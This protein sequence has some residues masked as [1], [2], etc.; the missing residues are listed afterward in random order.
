MGA[1]YVAHEYWFA[2]FQLVMAML[3]MGATLTGR[4][5]RDVVREPRAVT[6]G[7]AVQLLLVP[8]AAFAFLRLLGVS[9]GV[10]IGIAL[11]AS[12]PGGTT[13]NIFTFFARGNSALSISITGLTTLAC[14][15]TTPLILAA[16]ISDSLPAEFTMPTGQIVSEIAFTLLLPLALGMLYLY[17]YPAQ[18]VAVSKWCIRASLLGIVLIVVGSMTAGRLDIEA[19]GLGNVVLVVSFTLALVAIGWLASRLQRLP[20][21]D[22]TAIEF[23]VIVRNVNLGVMLKASLFPASAV[24]TGHL[25]DAVMFTLLLYGGLQLA[26]AAVLVPRYRTQYASG[27]AP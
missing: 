22:A 2:V 8:L 4:D 20:T 3:G 27:A 18:A 12:I 6:I 19:F 13:S 5:F 24:A 1:F 21:P 11:I 25:G 26:V 10:A 16:L 9:G 14:L 7:L 23:E 17:L 15:V